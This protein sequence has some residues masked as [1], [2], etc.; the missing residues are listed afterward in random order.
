MAVIIIVLIA[1]LALGILG[2]VVKGLIW[3]TI[4]AAI[5]FV[6]GAAFGATKLRGSGRS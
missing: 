1:L 2:T 6:V 3:L 4:I 5:L